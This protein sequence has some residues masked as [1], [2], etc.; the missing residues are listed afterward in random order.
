MDPQP[1][2][3][4]PRLLEFWRQVIDPS[5]IGM[6]EGIASDLAAF[7]G[8]PV[9]VVL[10]RM[11]NGKMALKQLW[12][13]RGIDPR[14]VDQVEAFYREQM[15]EAYELADWHCGR[16]NGEPPL[17]YAFAALFAQR[18]GLVRALDFGSGIGTGSVALASVGCEVHSADI[19]RRLLD[20]A[21]SRMAG[22]G[23]TPT[24]I[25]LKVETPRLGYYDLITC[26]DVL[27]HVP[28]QYAKIRELESYLRYGGHL[29]VN[30]MADSTDP[31]R[32]MHISSAGNWL[33]LVRRTGLKP[34][35]NYFT[36]GTQVLVRHKLAP[37]HNALGRVVDQLQGV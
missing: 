7:T 27:E 15:V 25:D 5:G 2:F 4:R 28:D 3:A 14:N 26:F 21:G 22:R 1:L 37:L 30:F 33:R 29:I 34:Q 12:L 8:E 20:L 32:P 13:E 24:L 36:E 16:T 35:W 11:A 10:S 23:Y 9:P 18:F 31:D 6:P 17:R 19:A